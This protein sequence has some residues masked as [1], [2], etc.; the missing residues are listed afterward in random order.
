MV[1][2]CASCFLVHWLLFTR[3]KYNFNCV[4]YYCFI[5]WCCLVKE[6]LPYYFV[7]W[8]YRAHTLCIFQD[9]IQLCYI[10]LPQAGR[11]RK[12]LGDKVLQYSNAGWFLFLCS[13]C[14]EPD[15]YSVLCALYFKG[16]WREQQHNSKYLPSSSRTD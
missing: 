9:E 12:N 1:S 10:K 11:Y 13:K 15:I 7:Y 8:V 14:N 6:P 16:T 5:L 2:L 4:L 3:L